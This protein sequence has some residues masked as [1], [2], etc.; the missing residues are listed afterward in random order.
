[1]EQVSRDN[2]EIRF[3]LDGLIDEFVEGVVE[4]LTPH[5]KSVLRVAQMQVRRVDK[6]ESLQVQR[7]PLSMYCV[8]T[9]EHFN[10]A[11][12]GVSDQ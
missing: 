10:L 3:Q 1:M 11:K 5:L 12:P 9:L 7:S 6:T 2:H 4:V 8:C